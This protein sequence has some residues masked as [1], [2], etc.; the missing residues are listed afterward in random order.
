MTL[1]TEL[2]RI[3]PLRADDHAGWLTLARGYKAF[4]KTD[5]PDAEYATAWQRLM[6]QDGVF[7]LGAH[8]PDGDG[9]AAGDRLVGITHY[10]F[11]TSTWAPRVC[12]LQDLFVAPEQRG[13][14]VARRLIDAVR[15]AARSAQASRCYWLTQEHN[16]TARKLYDRVAQF[17]GFIRYDLAL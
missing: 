3:T 12:Y 2:L 8:A 1:R 5:T 14:G 13:C 9:A 4:Y 10:L 6:T 15:E 11:H 7:G 16:T 17:N